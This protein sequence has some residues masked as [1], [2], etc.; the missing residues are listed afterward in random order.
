VRI[1]LTRPRGRG[2]AW[3]DELAASGHDVVLVPLTEIRDADPFPDPA[4]YDGVLFTSVSAVARAPEGVAWPR[5]G[6]VGKATAAA[7]LERGIGVDAV[8]AAGGA[9]L[10]AAWGT[11]MGQRLLLP[12]ARHAHPDLELA[13]RGMGA[14]V[15]CVAVYETA[16]APRVDRSALE[17]ADVIAFFAPSAVKVYRRLS[18]DTRARSWG[19]GATTRAAMERAGLRHEP[20]PPLD[21]MLD[22]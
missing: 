7:L 19:I 13:L 18:V 2:D 12:Q 22:G 17:S 9:E 14:D 4:S 16:P 1:V 15:T 10:A 8:G 5:V 20:C 3:R 6:A 11:A 21:A